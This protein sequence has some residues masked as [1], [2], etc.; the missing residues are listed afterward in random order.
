[1]SG[2][3][4]T[5]GMVVGVGD[6]EQRLQ[7]SSERGRWCGWKCG[8]QRRKGTNDRRHTLEVKLIGIRCGPAM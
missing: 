7:L 2:A 4:I 1:M 3:W 8:Q 5:E 6:L